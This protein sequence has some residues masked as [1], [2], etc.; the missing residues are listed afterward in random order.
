MG[1]A[2][3][4]LCQFSDA[5]SHCVDFLFPP[6]CCY[7]G[8]SLPET[9]RCGTSE[10]SQ[11]Y[12]PELCESCI[13]DFPAVTDN[14]CLKCGAVQGPHLPADEGCVHCQKSRFAFSGAVSLHLYEGV[15]RKMCRFCKQESG[16]KLAWYLAQRLWELEKERIKS[17]QCDFIVNVPMYW[18][19][20]LNRPVHP[21][22]SIATCLASN[23]NIPFWHRALKQIRKVPHQAKL[24]PSE[25]RKNVA[26]IY[27]ASRLHRFKGKNVLLVDDILTTGTTASE[28][29][30]VL[31]KA[32]AKD[33][34]VATVARGI[35]R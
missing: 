28:C 5:F 15:F 32:G 19:R 20:R 16:Q 35:G 6:T 23:L 14:H 9:V 24:A 17:W 12:L 10:Y 2:Q 11:V 18:T 30:K 22:E 1:I 25:R 3:P 7:C 13:S 21:A 26:G 4:S 34:Y 8:Q 29:S 33:V 31:K 27:R